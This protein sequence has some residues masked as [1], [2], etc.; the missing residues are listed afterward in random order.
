MIETLLVTK[1][2][3]THRSLTLTEL[4][5]RTT[6]LE[7][8][9]KEYEKELEAKEP[10]YQV[11][12][13]IRAMFLAKAQLNFPFLKDPYRPIAI[14]KFIYDGAVAIYK[15]D[16]RIDQ[17][18]ATQYPRLTTTYEKLYKIDNDF[19]FHSHIPKLLKLIDIQA[20]A[21]AFREAAVNVTNK[22]RL[23]VVHL[24]GDLRDRIEWASTVN[25]D[26][27]EVD[28]ELGELDILANEYFFLPFS[29]SFPRT[30]DLP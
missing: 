27:E 24:A 4:C 13:A 7:K 17:H 3:A 30:P 20:T 2:S 25:L 1:A 8:P 22:Q 15:A 16:G 6:R 26:D 11:G 28:C 9:S 21:R 29:K 10:L 14:G 23:E 12:L 5:N 19:V 18:V